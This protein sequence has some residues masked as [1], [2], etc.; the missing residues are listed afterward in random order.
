MRSNR[1]LFLLTAVCSLLS[2]CGPRMVPAAPA[3]GAPAGSAAAAPSPVGRYEFT[4]KFN[5]QSVS[6]HITVA[7]APGGYRG[8]LRS[9]ALSEITLDQVSLD[10]N[11]LTLAG[12]TEQGRLTMR[13]T[14]DSP[15]FTGRWTL[16]NMSEA[17]SG[18]RLD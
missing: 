15:V 1:N 3:P 16:G 2:A 14:L 17:I 9:P 11:V 8:V 5:G 13:L 18:H 4:S 7:G 6:G 10:G 12:S